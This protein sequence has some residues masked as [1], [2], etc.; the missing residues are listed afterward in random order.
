M[1]QM[2]LC[3]KFEFFRTN[4]VVDIDINEEK[5]IWLLK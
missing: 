2:Y 3:V 5:Q 1:A 4:E